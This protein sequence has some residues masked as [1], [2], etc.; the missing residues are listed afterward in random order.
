MVAAGMIKFL[1]DFYEFWDVGPS[2]LA[3]MALSEIELGGGLWL[4]M[5]IHHAQIGR[6]AVAA[7]AAFASASFYQ[8]VAGYCS[9]NRF[10]ERATSPWLALSLDMTSLA[11]LIGTGRLPMDFHNAWRNTGLALA[12]LAIGGA[13]AQEAGWVSVGGVATMGDSGLNGAVLNLSGKSGR[14]SVSTSSD[15]SFRLPPVRG[16]FYLVSTPARPSSPLETVRPVQQQPR[17]IGRRQ[18]GIPLPKV[19]ADPSVW[20]EIKDCGGESIAINFKQERSL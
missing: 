15:G 8:G 7:F 6:W 2:M 9:C 11:A 1:G 10:G 17:P 3:S 13:S 4:L 14:F 12:T 16:G 19:S 20:I 18:D 5:G